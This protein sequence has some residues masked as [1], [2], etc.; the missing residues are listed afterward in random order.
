[1][2]RPHT[3][4]AGEALI[5]QD[6][7]SDSAIFIRKGTAN[8]VVASK[9]VAQRSKGDLI[10][11]MTLLLGDVPGASVIADTAV[12]VYIVRHSALVE[13]LSSDPKLCGR[14]FRMMAATLSERI[15]E[16]SS[17]MRSEVVAKHSKKAALKPQADVST[18]NVTKCVASSSASNAHPSG[19]RAPRILSRASSHV[20]A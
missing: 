2:G 9:T 7:A 4:G 10:G 11:E 13:Q 1:M 6:K 18:L 14:V 17:K 8:I 12:D 20:G 5:E 19:A 3:Y 15:G 16:A